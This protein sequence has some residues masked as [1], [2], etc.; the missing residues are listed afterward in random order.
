[1]TT[2]LTTTG[3]AARA[4]LT[5]GVLMAIPV[6][7][8][9][10]GPGVPS[11]AQLKVAY[12][13][14]W[15]SNHLAAQLA[16][17]VA[18]AAWA[19]LAGWLAIEVVAT[20][21]GGGGRAP[22]WLRPVV[23]K[24]AAILLMASLRL[25]V[26]APM[27]PASTVTPVPVAK[28]SQA[29]QAPSA[30]V[31]HHRVVAGD[32]LWDLAHE[33]Y[34]NGLHWKVIWD[35]NFSVDPDPD[36]IL[37]GQMLVIPS[38]SGA[39]GAPPA[40]ASTNGSQTAPPATTSG[41]PAIAS[42]TPTAPGRPAGPMVPGA[43][44]R[45]VVPA[46]S[47]A[48]SQTTGAPR[49]AAPP[50]RA[51]AKSA[52][53]NGNRTGSQELV[54]AELALGTLAAAGIIRALMVL[55]RRQRN[56]CPLDR[57]VPQPG[58]ALVP[59]EVALRRAASP[60]SLERLEA[61]LGALAAGLSDR[62]GEL[63]TVL[64]LVVSADGAVRVCLD[65]H[66]TSAPQPFKVAEDAMAW[67]LAAATHVD[68]GL[69]DTESML[70]ALVSVGRTPGDE[71]VLVNL[72]AFG[73]VSL[74]GP[75][76]GDLLRAWVTELATKSWAQCIEVVSVGFGEELA[77]LDRLRPA[78]TLDDE[79]RTMV[80]QAEEVTRMV[81]ELGEGSLLAARL[82]G[83]P[84]NWAPQV[85]CC[86]QAP[87]R[88]ALAPLRVA[89]AESTRSGVILAGAGP[90]LEAALV[91]DTA[92]EDMEVAP[93][94]V[95]VRPHRLAESEAASLGSLVEVAKRTDVV[96]P[97][98][99][100]YAETTRELL[101]PAIF[102][103]P[104]DQGHPVRAYGPGGEATP[105]MNTDH[106]EDPL[107]EGR[108]LA[109]QVLDESGLFEDPGLSEDPVDGHG[110]RDAGGSGNAPAPERARRAPAEQS[111]IEMAVLG[112]VK[113]H[114]AASE[115]QGKVKEM[116]AY[117]ALHPE[118]VNKR[119]LM[120][121]LWPNHP[122]NPEKTFHNTV[123]EVRRAFGL[124]STGNPYF[125][126]ST[127]STYKFSGVDTD[128]ARFSNLVT[129]AGKARDEQARGYLHEALSRVRGEPFSGERGYEWISGPLA[130]E[131]G[132]F[133]D[134]M[135]AAIAEV[136]GAL[137]DAC[138]ACDDRP[139]ATWALDQG[140][141]ACPADE[142][143]VALRMAVADGPA[144]VAGAL[145]ELRRRSDDDLGDEV[146]TRYRGLCSQSSSVN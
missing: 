83:D 76:A 127:A 61:A 84:E 95:V 139:G 24:L 123:S 66:Q 17:G 53:A 145:E 29:N 3:R 16:T 40:P 81:D 10:Y 34:G 124:D 134:A 94:G 33:Y 2:A 86:A 80:A 107:A 97:E 75:R 144:E 98:D 35:A 78:E 49:L 135:T 8:L 82:R 20:R 63:P 56:H 101:D 36:L 146:L 90:M 58:P 106:G 9:A 118:G 143:L 59:T 104:E 30:L 45:P 26:G 122:G 1:M 65:R 37:P 114:G 133:F 39:Q 47:R 12:D 15:V 28:V 120:R 117:L 100:A 137:A 140:L 93:L 23:M 89:L 68:Q 77:A 125:V 111:G 60:E 129:Q 141:L 46:V 142:R 52:R 74:V 69:A 54:F 43:R 108:Q 55:R 44:I 19:Y 132:F 11:V 32:N 116:A 102:F 62:P 96:G 119:R 42:P 113:A 18:L 7:L 73:C 21:R 130:V 14:H 67:E 87:S 13:L 103:D 38:L 57:R 126:R 128:W 91:L 22:R 25:P 48:A 105:R 92:N 64:G 121:V 136:A 112:P 109:A 71:E 51:M 41:P 27:A 31:Q 99:P 115:L 85:A 70:P 50:P 72:E 79:V 6:A 88:E 4:V 5:L 131:D 110:Q 138:L